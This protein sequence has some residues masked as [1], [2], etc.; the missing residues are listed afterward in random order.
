MHIVITSSSYVVPDSILL[1]PLYV[2]WSS[3]TL[4]QVV[5]DRDGL[6]SDLGKITCTQ[7]NQGITA[8]LAG[9]LYVAGGTSSGLIAG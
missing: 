5:A 6:K 4:S 1:H 3:Q 2:K 8:Y 7:D 9:L